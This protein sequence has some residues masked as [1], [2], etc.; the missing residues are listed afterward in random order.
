M[1]GYRA[2][3]R[4]VRCKPFGCVPAS[5][6]RK[7]RDRCRV[8]RSRSRDP[9]PCFADGTSASR[10]PSVT[11]ERRR[12]ALPRR[13]DSAAPR[14]FRRG[15]ERSN[16]DPFRQRGCILTIDAEVAHRALDL[17]LSNEDLDG[18]EID[19]ALADQQRLRPPQGMD[20]LRLPPQHDARSLCIHQ[21]HKRAGADTQS[22]LDLPFLKRARTH[23]D[24]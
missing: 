22:S 13:T 18:V 15:V 4:S 20:P 8:E 23:T 11:A 12:R 21:T 14:C 17:R 7:V 1:S 3:R 6:V 9:G 2:A 16:L 5:L 24:G 10:M 19:G